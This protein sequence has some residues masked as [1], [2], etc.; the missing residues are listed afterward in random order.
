MPGV[1]RRQLLRTATV[2]ASGAAAGSVLAAPAQ[3]AP[4]AGAE[5]PAPMGPV[6]VGPDDSRY[7]YL[8]G[9][10]Q[11][12]FTGTPDEVRVVGSTGQVVQAVQAAVDAGK[13]IAVRSGGHCAEGWVDDPAVRVVID[14]SGMTQVGYDAT[15]R[16]FVVEPG[17]RLGEVYRR[18]VLGW[19]VTVPGGWCPGVGAGG[20]VCGGGYGVLSR[21]MGLVVDHLYAVEVVVVGK[22]GRA[23]AVVATREESDPNRELWWA[24]TGGGGGNFGVVTRYWLRSAGAGGDSPER[25]LPKAPTETINFSAQWPWQALE[26]DEEKFTRLIR[27]HTDWCERNSAPGAPATRLYADLTVGRK[28]NDLNL[29]SGQVYGSDADRLLDDY[30]AALSAGVG[31]PRNVVR[32]RQPWLAAALAGPDSSQYRLKIKS[33][34]LR[35]G[36]SDAQLAAIY[37]NMTR[38]QDPNLLFGSVGIASYGGQISAV[39]ADATAFPHRD[40]VLRIQYTTAWADPARDADYVDWLRTLYREVYA[41]TRGMPAPEDGAYINYPDDDLADPRINTSGV[42]WSTLYYKGNYPRLQRIKAA[43]DPK[44]VFG[45]TLGIEPPSSAR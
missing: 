30:L 15:R 34:Y 39:A 19:G 17:A 32:T 44:G 9:R 18:L 14:M 21:S 6:T 8:V 13:R 29:V 25:L 45:H 42:P 37:R 5:C 35:K 22:D 33:A 16:A 2:V 26:L 31:Q 27:N 7:P 40:A 3:A 10:G 24:H 41:D 20:H 28:A 12:R 23:S 38:E 11:R 36:F 43:W 1:N 4:A